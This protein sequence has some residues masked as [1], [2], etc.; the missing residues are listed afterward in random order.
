[1]LTQHFQHA[2]IVRTDLLIIRWNRPLVVALSHFE[3]RGQFVGFQF[4]RAEDAESVWIALDDSPQ[5]FAELLGIAH[6]ATFYRTSLACSYM[7]NRYCILED[8]GKIKVPT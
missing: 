6:Q 8:V 4:I 5:V 7:L 1:M 3:H 2:P